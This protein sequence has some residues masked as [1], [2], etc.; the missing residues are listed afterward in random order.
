[1]RTFGG[2]GR[3]GV[4]ALAVIALVQT[5]AFAEAVEG[6]IGRVY[7]SAV[8]LVVYDPNGRP[9]P[10]ALPVKIV[11]ATKFSGVK[12]IRGLR[13]NDAV[14]VTLHQEESRVWVADQITKFQRVNARPATQNP[15]PTMREF[16][17]NPVVRGA[18]TGAASGA[19]ASGL[20]GGKA[21]KGA[22]VGAGVGAAAGLL[23][24]LFSQPSSSGRSSDSNDQ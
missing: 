16:L 19:L 8:D 24:G 18:L 4:V 20:S 10:N 13:S 17:G 2:W 15:P 21:G 7:A 22:L 9:Y 12:T 23:E 14:G 1:M 6:R 11:K 5:V 3:S